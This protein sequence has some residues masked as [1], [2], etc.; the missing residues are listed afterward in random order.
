MPPSPLALPLLHSLPL[1]QQA[2]QGN[3]NVDEIVMKSSL[4]LTFIE[5]R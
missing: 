2:E 5:R 1:P 4:G 3:I